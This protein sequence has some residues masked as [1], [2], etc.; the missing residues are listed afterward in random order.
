MIYGQSAGGASVGVQLVSPL[1]EGLFSRAVIQSGA[2]VFQSDAPDI[3]GDAYGASTVRLADT[4]GCLSG[5][6]NIPSHPQI[7]DAQCMREADW[8]TIA[9][10]FH[11]GGWSPVVDGVYL[12]ESPK[13][14]LQGGRLHE[15]PI[16]IGGTLDEMTYFNVWYT[17]AAHSNATWNDQTPAVE[18]GHEA[19]PG[20]SWLTAAHGNLVRP[21]AEDHSS[22]R[23]G[24]A[25]MTIEQLRLF[26]HR[27]GAG[28][29][30][31]AAAAR[32]SELIRRYG[33]T[34]DEDAFVGYSDIATESWT[35]AAN[36]F[37]QTVASARST[38]VF[39]YLF[40]R[41]PV[42]GFGAFHGVEIPYEF[43]KHD[44]QYVFAASC[45]NY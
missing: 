37:A 39:Q 20:A 41:A 38:P 26:L 17:P 45:C 24:G 27:Y 32:V 18:P 15:V 40:A 14:A 42:Y 22:E 35:C 8:R 2:F 13:A 33:I 34:R 21:T 3:T 25:Q 16:I 29:N 5:A 6:A 31:T 23:M 12:T 44:A 7:V 11:G 4:L 36:N 10:Q 30:E 1:A 9:T 28:L 19:C 43:Y